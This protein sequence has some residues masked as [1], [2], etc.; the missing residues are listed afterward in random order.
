MYCTLQHIG[1]I[2]APQDSRYITAFDGLQL[3]SAWE[4][5]YDA[6]CDRSNTKIYSTII[7]ALV[8]FLDLSQQN[9]KA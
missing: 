3:K 8:S 9:T 1:E 5:F 4:V 7:K 6:C 2:A